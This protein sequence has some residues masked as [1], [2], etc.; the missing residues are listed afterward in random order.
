MAC[1]LIGHL[2]SERSMSEEVRVMAMAMR[3]PLDA[4]LFPSRKV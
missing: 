4:L 1:F 2:G 3:W